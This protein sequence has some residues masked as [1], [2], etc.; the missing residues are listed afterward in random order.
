MPKGYETEQ[1][2]INAR[3]RQ[4]PLA[5]RLKNWWWY[6]KIFVLLAVLVGG[7]LLYLFLSDAGRVEADY[8]V[9]MVTT[10]YREEDDLLRLESRLAAYGEDR[11][12]DGQIQVDI[13]PY[14]AQLGS[15]ST[16]GYLAVATLD[17][18]L[19]GCRS[20]LFL[21]EDPETFQRVTGAL[22]YLDG[23][24]PEEGAED[25]ENM[26]RLLD[27]KQSPLYI[28]CRED[29]GTDSDYLDDSYELMEKLLT[30]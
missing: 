9:G 4:K 20:G 1:D 25:W 18:D 28:A 24:Q 22:R 30:D 6:N 8:H 19:V 29:N 26:A 23:S 13:T 14:Y 5:E 17:A 16:E 3:M 15:E 27:D 12:G 2:R 11:N 10:V 7:V 21:L